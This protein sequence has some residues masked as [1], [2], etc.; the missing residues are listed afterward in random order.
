MIFVQ[1]PENVRW[2]IAAWFLASA[3]NIISKKK[4]PP[5]VTSI[6]PPYVSNHGDHHTIIPPY[7]TYP[8]TVSPFHIP[9]NVQVIM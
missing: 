9:R 2:H 8:K 4:L 6:L 1:A 7:A 3:Y 5:H